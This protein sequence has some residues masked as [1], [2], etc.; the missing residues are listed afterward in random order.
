MSK[1]S[2][3]RTIEQ[4]YPQADVVRSDQKRMSMEILYPNIGNASLCAVCE[5]PAAER[6]FGYRL[7]VMMVTSNQ[8][9]SLVNA[10]EGSWRN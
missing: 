7:S 3:S 2:A 10:H 1:S 4:K 9:R 6:R 8:K 5:V